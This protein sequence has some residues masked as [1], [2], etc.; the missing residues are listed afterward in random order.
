MINLSTITDHKNTQYILDRLTPAE[1]AIMNVN[2]TGLVANMKKSYKNLDKDLF[3]NLVSTME[4]NPVYLQPIDPA[5]AP[6]A[7]NAHG[8][9]NK[10]I[11]ELQQAEQAHLRQEQAIKNQIETQAINDANDAQFQANHQLIKENNE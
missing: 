6:V 5:K 3:I 8:T 2:F 1:M 10:S 7:L 9:L 11:L 4:T